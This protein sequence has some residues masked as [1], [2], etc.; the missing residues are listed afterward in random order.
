MIN[1]SLHTYQATHK[2]TLLPLYITYKTL[3]KQELINCQTQSTINDNFQFNYYKYLII[4]TSIQ[5]IENIDILNDDDYNKLFDE[6][7]KKSKVSEDIEQV[8]TKTFHILSDK[9]SANDTWNC[10][11]CKERGLQYSRNCPLIDEGD[12]DFNYIIQGEVYKSCPIGETLNTK[13]LYNSAFYSYNLY[14]KGLL[15]NSGGFF[16]QTDFFVTSVSIIE[17][18]ISEY[19]QKELEKMNK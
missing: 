12:K 15:P 1:T 13:E 16:D 9:N 7:I 14:K 8:L 3:T 19:E 18:L 5:E 6:I 17:N 10:E 2:N 11:V 4:K